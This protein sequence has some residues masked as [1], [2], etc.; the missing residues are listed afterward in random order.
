MSSEEKKNLSSQEARSMDDI[1]KAKEIDS[2]DAT[3]LAEE[4]ENKPINQQAFQPKTKF[5]TKV[6]IPEKTK[7]VTDIPDAIIPEKD[8]VTDQ[9]IK[10]LEEQ[11]IA[12]RMG[13]N[14]VKIKKAPEKPT[15]IDFTK[16]TEDSVYDLDIPIEAI[17]HDIP[18]FLTVDL[19][20]KNYAPRWIHKTPR[21]LGPML[22]KGWTYV[23]VED[24]TDP[25][26]LK[27][28]IDENG[29]FRFDDVILC[30]IPK[31]KYF[32]QLRANHERALM[33][34]NP[35]YHH[36]RSKKAVE[37]ALQNAPAGGRVGKGYGDYVQEGKLEVYVPGVK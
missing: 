13:Q 8:L 25:T 9:R 15:P 21:R 7:S 10:A 17:T 18:D 26:T 2:L 22:A 31:I 14:G 1:F 29:H 33:Q 16:L 24:L 4:F 20:D 23:T 5:P 12:L 36:E 32:G 11:I 19:K 37:G 34:V 27:E 28:T 6:T 35:K 30:K 3:K